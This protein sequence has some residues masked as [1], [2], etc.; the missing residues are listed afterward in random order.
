MKGIL[1]KSFSFLFYC[2]PDALELCFFK[3]SVDQCRPV[4]ARSLKHFLGLLIE[5]EEEKE[6]KKS[7]LPMGSKAW[8]AVE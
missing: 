8:A 6:T 4:L 5:A 3:R 2:K 1:S 7:R